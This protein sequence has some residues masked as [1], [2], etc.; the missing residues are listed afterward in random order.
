MSHP[1]RNLDT[2]ALFNCRVPMRDGITLAA[3]VYLP[4]GTGKSFPVILMFSPYDAT[5]GRSAGGMTWAARGFAFV[6]ADCR[7]RFKSEGDFVPWITMK[8]DS[9]ALL[10]W[11]AK[12]SWCNGRV[13]MV[14]GSY[15]AATQLAAAASGHP[16]LKAAAPS[17]MQSDPYGLYYRGGAF[18]L[19]FMTGWHIG[20][21]WRGRTPA[22][23]PDWTS[24]MRR[25]PVNRIDTLSGIPCPSWKSATEHPRYD[26]FWKDLSL[27]PG[28]ARSD[29]SL[30][31]QGGWFDPICPDIL[32]DFTHASGRYT[33]LRMGPWAHGVNT[34]E[35]EIDYGPKAL[36]SEDAEIDFLTSVLRG[37]KPVTASRAAPLSLFIMGANIWRQEREWPLKRTQWTPF[38]LGS[39]GRANTAGGNGWLSRAPVETGDCPPDHFTYD[40]ENPVPSWGGRG[41]GF[42]GQRNQAEIEKRDDVLVYSLP[43][44]TEDL[45]ATGPVTA[46]LYVSSS[47]PDTD[48]TVKLV[49]VFPDGRPFNVCDGIQRVRYQGRAAG[50]PKP[51]AKGEV[52]EVGVDVDCTAYVFR[53]GHRIRVEISSS[54]FPHYSR[55]LNTFRD[56]VKETEPRTAEQTI[57][58]SAAHPSRIILP[59]IPAV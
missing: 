53:R 48:F 3:D 18:V 25:Y 34:L 21:T 6:G 4:P 12:Q 33:C 10:D 54:S 37:R 38:Y 46:V 15:V 7:G 29:A 20:M 56:P 23:T 24:L 13:G 30:F 51:L 8:A 32:D 1:A 22:T 55:H 45:E 26:A 42:G 49:D 39:C 44:L 41:V 47:A 40:P 16:A 57:H 14:G 28:M 17:A 35:G 5:S 50:K 31:M 27:Q 9:A 36:V 11:I 58:H 59:V 52:R 2:R 19:A 43:P